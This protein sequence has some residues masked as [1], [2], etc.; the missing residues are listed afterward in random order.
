MWRSPLGPCRGRRRTVRVQL[1]SR[2]ERPFNHLV[3]DQRSPARR[4]TL[5]TLA[6]G[7]FR[8]MSYC[9]PRRRCHSCKWAPRAALSRLPAPGGPR[10]LGRAGRVLPGLLRAPLFLIPAPPPPLHGRTRDVGLFIALPREAWRW[11]PNAGLRAAGILRVWS[12]RKHPGRKDLFSFGSLAVV[13]TSLEG[14]H[15]CVAV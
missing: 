6:A 12:A 4:V 9:R 7:V 11:C 10:R 1:T 5:G 14:P 8:G 13:D 2:R 3:P 15:S